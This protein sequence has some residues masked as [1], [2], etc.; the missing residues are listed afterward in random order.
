MDNARFFN[1]ALTPMEVASLYTETTP[2]EEPLATLVDPFKDGSGKALYR[3]EGNALDESGNHNL[4]PNGTYSYVSAFSGRA[5]ANSTDGQ[6]LTYPAISGWNSTSS[7]SMTMWIYMTSNADNTMGLIDGRTAGGLG[8]SWQWNDGTNRLKFPSGN[9]CTTAMALNTWYQLTFNLN[10]ATNTW[11]VIQ[12]DATNTTLSSLSEVFAHTTG[13]NNNL[14]AIQNLGTYSF[15]G[16]MKN[17]RFFNRQITTD[18]ITTLN[19]KGA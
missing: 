2:M 3:L 9:P 12:R 6:Y 7:G 18:E 16:Y 5:I 4:T 19:T 13:G 11:T 8:A 1:K 15:R 10:R 17:I 14:G